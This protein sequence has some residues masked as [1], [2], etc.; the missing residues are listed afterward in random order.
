MLS[1]CASP[2]K[3]VKFDL[4]REDSYMRAK[5]YLG[6]N[7]E[8][9][10]GISAIM[11]F[12]EACVRLMLTS[13]TCALQLLVNNMNDHNPFARGRTMKFNF[14]GEPGKEFLVSRL[15]RFLLVVRLASTAYNL[16]SGYVTYRSTTRHPPVS[17][18]LSQTNL[19]LALARPPTRHAPT[20]PMLQNPN[21]WPASLPLAT[22]KSSPT[23]TR[24]M[25][26]KSAVST[27]MHPTRRHSFQVFRP[28]TFNCKSKPTGP[29]GARGNNK[30]GDEDEDAGGDEDT[31]ATTKPG[32]K[33][34]SAKGDEDDDAP[35][36]KPEKKG[37]GKA[38]AGDDDDDDTA[39]DAED[40]P[41]DKKAPKD[42]KAKD[43]KK[44]KGKSGGRIRE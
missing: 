16:S 8:I 10:V 17:T 44:G 32:K 34:K 15:I 21:S 12:S 13:D 42:A 6:V 40:K 35:A 31:P 28:L 24:L 7:A 39:G 9:W 22:S 18:K 30:G 29:T 1:D 43:K 36:S 5:D 14:G 25:F 38:G 11:A 3:Q 4:R 23:A 27:E 41:K 2:G 33:G 26:L 37:K 20:R 19:S